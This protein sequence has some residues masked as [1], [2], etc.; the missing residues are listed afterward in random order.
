MVIKSSVLQFA[1]NLLRERVKFGTAHGVPDL[2]GP[3]HKSK[4][5]LLKQI[6]E[7]S[8]NISKS[9]LARK[10]RVAKGFYSLEMAPPTNNEIKQ[11]KNDAKLVKEFFGS[12]AYKQLTVKQAWLLLLVGTEVGM[13][14]FLGE[15]IGKMH[16]VGYKV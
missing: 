9:E 6:R 8:D 11:I 10:L 12:G 1:A 13:W 16:I 5:D 7:I 4:E 3:F 2:L 15:T 14:F